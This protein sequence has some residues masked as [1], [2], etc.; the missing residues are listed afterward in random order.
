M[1]ATFFENQERARRN[2]SG[3]VLLFTAGVLSLIAFTYFLIVVLY[4]GAAM[5]SEGAIE[6]PGFWQPK[7]LLGVTL[8][9]VVLVG[10]GSLFK[11]AQLSGGGSA[12][13]WIGA[14]AK[15]LACAFSFA[16]SFMSRT[17]ST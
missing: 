2:T 9:I 15:P 4:F 7:V 14:S 8:G 13:Q 1:G 5:K 3:L 12:G 6:V 16:Q 17:A 10:G 11:L